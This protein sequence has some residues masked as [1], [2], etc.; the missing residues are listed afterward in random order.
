MIYNV[1][2]LVLDLTFLLVKFWYRTFIGIFEAIKGIEERDVSH[3]IVLITGTGHGIGK[4]LALQYSALGSVVVCWDI[5]EEMNQ[6][7]VKLIKAR[8]GRA[9]G[10][11]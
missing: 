7:T 2:I 8:G 3:D 4:E 6:E 5:N 11:T 9:H 1:F 10:Y